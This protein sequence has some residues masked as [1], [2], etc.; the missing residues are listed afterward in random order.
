M[1]KSLLGRGVEL[2]RVTLNAAAM[3]DFKAGA[4]VANVLAEFDVGLVR[5]VFYTRYLVIEFCLRFT[6][7]LL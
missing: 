7:S 4:I 5:G 1:T 6:G 3:S 2:N